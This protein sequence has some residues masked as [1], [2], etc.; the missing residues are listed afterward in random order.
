MECGGGR[1]EEKERRRGEETP[2][3]WLGK[4]RD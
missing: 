2:D 3:G 1:I 4:V